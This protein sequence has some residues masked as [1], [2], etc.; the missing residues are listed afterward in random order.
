MHD[1]FLYLV[2]ALAT[3]FDKISIARLDLAVFASQ[4]DVDPDDVNKL[5][6]KAPNP[7]LYLL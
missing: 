3:V 5:R 1:G 4:R 2:Q 6:D 7:E